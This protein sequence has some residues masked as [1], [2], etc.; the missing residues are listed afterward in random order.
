MSPLTDDKA[1]FY[2]TRV[3]HLQVNHAFISCDIFILFILNLRVPKTP[4]H[5]F[6]FDKAS[7]Q[8]YNFPFHSNAILTVKIGVGYTSVTEI[9]I[10]YYMYYASFCYNLHIPNLIK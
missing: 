1:M 10:G 8:V 9:E 2:D 7:T 4:R 6:T 5:I 3:S